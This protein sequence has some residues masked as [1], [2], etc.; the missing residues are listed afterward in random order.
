MLSL[1]SPAE[2]PP[3]VAPPSVTAHPPRP[4]AFRVIA[5]RGAPDARTLIEQ[6]N[7]LTL[8]G[9]PVT[10]ESRWKK[11][12]PREDGRGIRFRDE[13]LSLEILPIVTDSGWVSVEAVLSALV[14]PPGGKDPLKPSSSVT[15]TVTMGVPFEI[16]LP[17]PAAATEDPAGGASSAPPQ[18]LI[19]EIVPYRPNE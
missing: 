8:E 3:P 14:Y 11:P 2:P 7:L 10:W 18:S 5:Y 19:V 15:R 17:L 6:H 9:R 12:I 1:S 13:G 4:I 16:T